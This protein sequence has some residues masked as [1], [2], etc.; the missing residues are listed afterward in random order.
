MP[1]RI[2]S[3]IADYAVIGDCRTAA[4]VSSQGSIDWLCW[5]QFDS[6][7]FL[8]RLLDYDRGGHFTIMPTGRFSVCRTYKDSAA[9]LVTEFHTNDGKV[10]VTD[11]MPVLSETRK[12]TCLFPFRSVLRWV[13]GIEGSV[14]LQV[15]LKPR[16]DNGRIV[17]SFHARGASGYVADLR[18]GLLYLATDLR[19]EIKNGELEARTAVKAGQ[20]HV[21]WLTYSEDAPAVYPVM[22]QAPAALEETC[23]Y[24]RNWAEACTY[25]GPYRDAVLRSALTLKQLSFAPSGA[26]VA[27]PT[28]SLPEVIG[29][30]RNWDYRYCWLRD[31][32]YTA[33]A[34]LRIGFHEE[35]LAFMR[36]LLHATAL[37]YPGLQVMYDVY[38]EAALAEEDLNFLD[39]YQ[40]SRPVRVGNQAHEQFQL[41]IY[42]ELLDA[43]LVYVEAGNDLDR[44]M[45]HRLVKIADLVSLQWAR[46]DHG[47]W[48]VRGEPRQYV[49]SKVMCWVA[50]D[51]AERIARRLGILA[52]VQAWGEA[53][54]AI[55]R[56]VLQNGYS[57]QLQSFVQ[58]LDGT[59]VDATSLTFAP[60]GFI[61]P[62]DPRFESTIATVRTIL[63]RGDLLYR[64]RDG[65]ALSGEEGAF[66]P[67]SFW[68][69]EALAI[70]GQWQTADALFE[71]LQKFANDVGLYSEE[72]EPSDGSMLGNFPQALTHLAH[73]GA[74]LRL[75]QIR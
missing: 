18:R 24:W 67:C 33:Q 58:T 38:G 49:H 61:E 37:T 32:S 21:C 8:N 69:V 14:E 31:A 70:A 57:S 41:D 27:A 73:I 7:S 66:L 20:H 25:Q 19:L 39:G 56:T 48:E 6:P 29:G 34:F 12:R 11:L 17:P 53:R 46:P 64:Y 60:T 9:V 72:T 43:V 65:D 26:I 63:G 5:P 51:R 59:N 54:A 15:V 13:E 23:H 2:G 36:W 30:V 1:F 3:N 62:N 44:E 22:V 71:R 45:R 35:A 42:G 10:R 68:L 40:G 75:N 55:R 28:T 47:I 16:P 52:D 4:L 50:L 74:A